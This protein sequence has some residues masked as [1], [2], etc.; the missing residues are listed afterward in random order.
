MRLFL[1]AGAVFVWA[2]VRG[3]ALG[4]P[5]ARLDQWHHFYLAL[6]VAVAAIVTRRP[7]LLLVASLLAADDAW[8]HLQQVT[9][10]W[11]YRSPLHLWF[12]HTLWPLQPVQRVV[13]WLNAALEWAGRAV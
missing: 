10:D 12:A 3:M 11:D 4:H 2:C 13:G 9:G 1:C 5:E 8:Q 6:P 7:W